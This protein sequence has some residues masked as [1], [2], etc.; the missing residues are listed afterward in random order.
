MKNKALVAVTIPIYK[1]EIDNY[2]LISLTQCVKVLNKYNIIFYAPN[3]LDTTFY[4]NFCEGKA[5]YQI[6][7][8]DDH[9]FTGIPGYNKLMLSKGFYQRFIDYKYILVYQLDAFIFRDELEY[10][11]NKNYFYIGAPYIFVD[12]DKYPIKFLTKYRRLL[13]ILNGIGIKIYTYRHVGNGGLSLRHVS[14]TL[15]LLSLCNKSAQSWASLMEDNFFC[16]WGNVLFF[17]FNLAKEKDAATFSIEL[18]P[19]E[20]FEFIGHQIPF[21]THAFLKYDVDFWRPIFE[22]AGYKI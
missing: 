3:S 14:K 6:E 10:W 9:Y 11:C 18:H 4:E 16:Y 13:K 1:K 19:R 20:T 5:Q 22:S 21:G 7:R 12:L 2:E 8:F 17:Y 15:H